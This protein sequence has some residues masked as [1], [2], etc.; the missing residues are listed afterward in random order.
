MTDIERMLAQ[1]AEAKATQPL[2]ANAQELFFAGH[3]NTQEYQQ[4]AATEQVAKRLPDTAMVYPNQTGLGQRDGD[5]FTIME[6][7]KDVAPFF[8]R[9]VKEA[10]GRIDGAISAL[11]PN[12]IDHV[13]IR[14]HRGD[15]TEVSPSKDNVRVEVQVDCINVKKRTKVTVASPIDILIA[16]LRPDD[17]N[18]EFWDMFDHMLVEQLSRVVLQLIQEIKAGRI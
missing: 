1:A 4:V 3:L 16:Y 18:K 12:Q 8:N 7:N 17:E 15:R 5:V 6:G 11:I 9:S 10:R 14:A 2:S 13:I